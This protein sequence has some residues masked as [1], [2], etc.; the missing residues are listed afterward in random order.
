LPGH[1][2]NLTLDRLNG[3]GSA[4]AADRPHR[5]RIARPFS[6]WFVGVFRTF[7]SNQTA[8]NKSPHFAAAKPG[9]NAARRASKQIHAMQKRAM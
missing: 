8:N 7:R 6:P 4:K 1:G 5:T 3:I 9:E 2:L